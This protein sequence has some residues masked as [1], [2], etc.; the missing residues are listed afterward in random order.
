MK[1]VFLSISTI[2]LFF[3][4]AGG[5]LEEIVIGFNLPL[6]ESES[7]GSIGEEAK[8]AAEMIRGQIDAAG[9][10]EVK[11]LRY[12]LRFI[13]ANNE[14]EA[15]GA[16]RAALRLVEEEQVLAVVGP[17]GSGRAIPAGEVCNHSE[18]PMIS[19]WSTNPETTRNR[20]FV[21]RTCFLDPFQAPGAARFT[22]EKFAVSKA[23]IL[24]NGDDDY[25]KTLAELYRD[26]W[27]TNYGEVVA[28]ESFEQK[29]QDF[30]AQLTNIMASGAEILYLPVYYNFL[31]PIVPQAKS[32]GWDKPIMGA[33]AWGSAD[34]WNISG[35]S[36]AGYYFTTHFVS[37][38]LPGRGSEFIK[39]YER[40]YGETPSDVGALTYDSVMLYLG[41]LQRA[42]ISG[43]LKADR[44]ALQRALAETVDFNGVAGKIARFDRMGDPVKE[45]I[46]AKI[47]SQG[48]F[49]YEAAIPPGR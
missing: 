17:L 39:E 16:V 25:S 21:F 45:I 31:G 44:R 14:A 33:D 40:L 48:R 36:V 3:S 34:L 49:V 19:P 6:T 20:P 24:Y 30:N 23:A 18:T 11:G 32:L 42:G 5:Y 13:Y 29:D 2:L 8:N 41:A 27:N 28:W 10:L 43:V 7:L 15:G 4:L 26:S 47:N 38:G 12:P 35:G 1:R 46:V 37:S 9:G 22:K